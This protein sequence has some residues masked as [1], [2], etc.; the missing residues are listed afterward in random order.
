[1]NTI[2]T[3]RVEVHAQHLLKNA[4]TPFKLFTLKSHHVDNFYLSVLK[5]GKLF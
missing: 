2:T 3:S 1:M 4:L 5:F